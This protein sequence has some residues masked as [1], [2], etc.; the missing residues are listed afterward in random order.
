MKKIHFSKEHEISMEIS[1][2]VDIQLIQ[3]DQ[4]FSGFLPHS[5]ILRISHL[6]FVHVCT[7]KV[8][9]SYGSSQWSWGTNKE[10]ILTQEIFLHDPP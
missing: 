2:M 1:T 7:H 8:L 9:H 10:H 5:K 4:H 3:Y 6:L